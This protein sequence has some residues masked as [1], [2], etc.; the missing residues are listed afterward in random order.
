[1]RGAFR[2]PIRG[3]KTTSRFGERSVY[4]G[5]PRS[6]HSGADIHA[7]TGTPVL[8]PQSGRVALADDYFF[9][10]RTVIVDHGLGVYSMFAHLSEIKAP[11]G[12]FVKR[13][14]VVGLAGATGRVTGPHLHWAMKILG[15]RVDPQSVIAL[16]LDRWLASCGKR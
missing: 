4:N 7:S 1:M 2:M 6:P 15:A 5:Q 16:P 9:P 8:A 13:G 11:P 12:K 10:G 14:D 3:A